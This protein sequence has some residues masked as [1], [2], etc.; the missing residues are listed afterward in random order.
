MMRR[1]LAI[2]MTLVMLVGTVLTYAP[3]FAWFSTPQ[4]PVWHDEEQYAG[5]N[6]LPDILLDHGPG[7]VLI[8]ET[9]HFTNYNDSK[10]EIG[11]DVWFII[12]NLSDLHA[13]ETDYELLVVDPLV[14]NW[15]TWDGT[16]L[17]GVH[18][19]VDENDAPVFN[20][21]IF[22]V[23]EGQQD[24]AFN[25]RDYVS[26]S[27]GPDAL[28]LVGTIDPSIGTIED[29]GSGGFL[30][31]HDGSNPNPV[32]IDGTFEITVT[33]GLNTVTGLVNMK[34]C[35]RPDELIAYDDTLIVLEDSWGS[36]NVVT[37][38]I[39]E[40][41]FGHIMV[42]D[43][44]IEGFQWINIEPRHGEA[45][46]SPFDNQQ[47]VYIPDDDYVGTDTVGYFIMD[48]SFQVSYAVLT[49][50]VKGKGDNIY[51]MNNDFM[52]TLEGGHVYKNLFRNDIFFS[53]VVNVTLSRLP[54]HGTVDIGMDGMARY[55]AD[56][57]Y[58]GK[59]WFE[60]EVT[61]ESGE[62][63]H[64]FVY[65]CI[66]ERDKI[67]LNDDVRTVLENDGSNVKNYFPVLDNDIILAG[68]R[69]F[70]IYHYQVTDG[71]FHGTV[72]VEGREISYIPDPGFTGIDTFRYLVQD[73]D[74]WVDV[75]SVIVSVVP[76]DMEELILEDF[77]IGTLKTVAVSQ[78]VLGQDAL[79]PEN[80]PAYFDGGSLTV[81]AEYAPDSLSENG[82]ITPSG[83]SVIFNP[84]NDERMA[85][86]KYTVSDMF[87]HKGVG[88]IYVL[89]GTDIRFAEVIMTDD[90]P[91]R[92]DQYSDIEDVRDGVE[93]IPSAGADV[94]A[95]YE[96]VNFASNPPY[97]FMDSSMMVDGYPVDMTYFY[98]DFKVWYKMEDT[99]GLSAMDGSRLVSVNAQ[100]LIS[101]DPTLDPT[102]INWP[103]DAYSVARSS[104]PEYDEKAM[105][106]S[107]DILDKLYG[108]DFENYNHPTDETFNDMPFA[109]GEEL[110][111]KFYLPDT[112]M[113]TDMEVEPEY[114]GYDI[115]QFWD[116]IIPGN[117]GE[118]PPGA[119]EG[120]VHNGVD[121][122]IYDIRFTL[123]DAEDFESEMTDPWAFKV[124]NN[125]PELTIDD[126]YILLNEGETFTMKQGVSAFDIEDDFLGL[127]DYPEITF[128]IEIYG[129]EEWP[130][131]EPLTSIDTSMAGIYMVHY[132]ATDSYGATDMATRFVIVV[133]RP[134]I[135][136]DPKVIEIERNGL[137]PVWNGIDLDFWS[138]GD[139]LWEDP[140]PD[141]V[142]DTMDTAVSHTTEPDWSFKAFI[143]DPEDEA[144]W[145]E[146]DTLWQFQENGTYYINYVAY[147]R[148]IDVDYNR[149]EPQEDEPDWF[150]SQTVLTR[151]IHVTDADMGQ[152]IYMND[153]N[154]N[155]DTPD[156]VINGMPSDDISFYDWYSVYPVL[157][158]YNPETNHERLVSAFTLN[159]VMQVSAP[160]MHKLDHIPF[161]DIAVIPHAETGEEMVYAL[162]DN[163]VFVFDMNTMSFTPLFNIYEELYHLYDHLTTEDDSLEN[164]IAI[165]GLGVDENG[166]L[167]VPVAL[168]RLKYYYMNTGADGPSIFDY[169][170]ILLYFD[171]YG[172]PVIEQVEGSQ[173]ESEPPLRHIVGVGIINDDGAGYEQAENPRHGAPI[174]VFTDAAFSTDFSKLYAIGGY[175]SFDRMD[176][177][178]VSVGEEDEYVIMSYVEDTEMDPSQIAEYQ[179]IMDEMARLPED[180]M[181]KF[182][183]LNSQQGM[184]DGYKYQGIASLNDDIYVTRYLSPDLMFRSEGEGPVFNFY[185]TDV[186]RYTYEEKNVLLQDDTDAID[187]LFFGALGAGNSLPYSF[188]VSPA[189]YNIVLNY[190][191]SASM[192]VVF[193]DTVFPEAFYSDRTW[194]VMTNSDYVQDPANHGDDEANDGVFYVDDSK[195]SDAT[196]RID[197]S[198]YNNYTRMNETRTVYIY[199]DYRT[200]PP[201]PAPRPTTTVGV[202]LDTDAVTLA[203]GETAEEEL[204]FY[205][206][207]ETVTGTTNKAVTWELDDDTFATVD[208]NGVVSVRD[209]VEAGTGDIIVE[210]T[211]RTVVGNAT[212]TATILFEEQTPLGA[213]EF[214]DPYIYGYT[215]NTFRPKNFVTRAEVATMFTKILKL[216][217]EF[218]GSQSFYDVSDDHWAYAY[219][220]AM[221][222]SGIFVGS[223]DQDGQRVFNPEAPISRAEIAQ[224]FSNYWNFL[225]ISVTGVNTT[226]IPDVPAGHW[227][228]SAI[229]RLYNTGIFTGYADGSFKP[230]EPTLREQIV[231]MINALINRP[232][233]E[234]ETSKFTDIEPTDDHYGDIEAASQTFLKPQ[235]E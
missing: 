105:Y 163:S 69:K 170:N 158:K 73:K 110:M 21:L 184:M 51:A 199:V 195:T 168:D 106:E 185:Q 161:D 29:D 35:P 52:C 216:N 117:D 179:Y 120:G 64:A 72:E 65:V 232:P 192:K 58:D 46:V 3:A 88:Y 62:V 124:M 57:T 55:D 229:N 61:L 107:F 186:L 118:L 160:E 14:D 89:V 68:I 197:V 175:F 180:F 96:L 209:D 155:G 153:F 207:T 101:M 30:Y 82:I 164:F 200:R 178:Q 59:D 15:F 230:F 148:D 85:K 181:I 36:T 142:A 122:T 188:T 86:I 166:N 78:D 75:A 26:D 221:F 119:R 159:F 121:Y 154:P 22:K 39:V 137:F 10:V 205:D 12:E 169:E 208:E 146:V 191:E 7:T 99:N 40:N 135:E 93:Y 130:E 183:N 18:L 77:N 138:P 13:S 162:A 214:F 25:W 128:D 196:V 24:K 37:N 31:S 167:I 116:I 126:A 211:V 220:Q 95:K 113:D 63:G 235:G 233:N 136:A 147:F 157:M 66:G 150:Y 225:D 100:P 48:Q 141:P 4:P 115:S 228:S 94:K 132:T 23:Y 215:D 71:P 206:F 32:G 27:D 70:E 173:P 198:A 6:T 212:D 133:E 156:L 194:T 33:D 90:T 213:I 172:I 42:A 123:T 189:S 54:R 149:F 19:G 83:A 49:I 112:S 127:V 20:D 60:Y 111:I 47:I 217:T 109:P 53:E 104:R 2:I 17:Y 8:K 224:V 1:P 218:P 176:Y 98:G 139:L 140:T 190:Q 87:G 151:T 56:D 102:D 50:D 41:G 76:G 171:P 79:L 125:P 143:G 165:Q 182:F 202:T 84:N 203:Y 204:T 81:D 91:L 222:R 108:F 145:V 38:D 92:V 5:E 9:T 131:V 177:T 201:A 227:A 144:S 193:T 74:R 174:S 210:V 152:V 80:L 34:V 219:I 187:G 129:I 134:V 16:S 226:P 45:F 223:F 28:S 43:W 11:E 103:E 67:L 231:T 114:I 97:G 234:P 44:I